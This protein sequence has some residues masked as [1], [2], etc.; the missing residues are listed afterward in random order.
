MTDHG[1]EGRRNF[2]FTLWGVDTSQSKNSGRIYKRL[3]SVAEMI[4]VVRC[5]I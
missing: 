3:R 5:N 1:H 2:R 4:G